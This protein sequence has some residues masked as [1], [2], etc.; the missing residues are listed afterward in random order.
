MSTQKPSGYWTLENTIAEVKAV[1]TEHGPKA[2][3]SNWLK[4][5]GHSGLNAAICGHGGIHRVR[6]L[7]GLAPSGVKPVGYWTLEN[8]VA[9]VKVIADEHGPEAVTADWLTHN[10]HSGLGHAIRRRG[11]LSL[12]RELADLAGPERKPLGYWTLENTVA[13]VKTVAAEHGPEAVTADWLIR[14][15]HSSLNTAIG[16]HGGLHHIRELAGL[17]GPERK[18]SG[19]WTLENTVAEVKAI[20]AKH[21][22]EA[23]T[24][25]WLNRNGYGGLG[26]AMRQ[27]GGFPRIRELAG[28]PDRLTIYDQL[29]SDL[30]AL[31]ESLGDHLHE[32]PQKAWLRIIKQATAKI[33][34]QSKLHP[35]KVKLLTGEIGPGDIL[36]PPQPERPDDDSAPAEPPAISKLQAELDRLRDADADDDDDVQDVQGDVQDVVD[37]VQDDD[38]ERRAQLIR[39]T[40]QRVLDQMSVIA[41]TTSDE[42]AL[43]SIRHDA[44]ERLWQRLF[45][46][47]DQAAEVAAIRAAVPADRWASLLRDSF[48]ADWRLIEEIGEI[49]GFKAD[50]GFSLN[51]MQRR[52]AALLLRDRARLNIS[53]MGGGKTLA[54]IAAAH[55]CGCQ[56]VLVLAPNSALSAWQSELS[57][58][59]PDTAVASK[60][61][62]PHWMPTDQPRW[63]LNNHEMLGDYSA[64]ELAVFIE[65]HEPDAVIIDE[66][67]LCKMRDERSESQRHRNLSTLCDQLRG[68]AVLLGL[69]GTPVV[70]ELGEAIGLLQLIR[71]DLAAGLKPGHTIDNCMAVHEALQPISSR[72]IP[73][74]PCTV[75]E[76]HIE[77]RADHL[78]DDAVEAC[79]QHP[80]SID[81]VLAQAKLGQLVT[82]C[83]RPGKTVVFTSSVKGVVDAARDALN[84]AGIRCVVHTGQEKDDAGV[85]SVDLFLR[86]PA[87]RVL[88]ASTGTLATGFDGLQTVCARLCYLTLPWTPAEYDQSKHRVIRQGSTATEIELFTISAVLFD[89]EGEEDWSYDTQKLGVLTGKRTV[90][91]AVT[92]G[93]IPDQSAL[94][95]SL[96]EARKAHKKMLKRVKETS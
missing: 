91:A 80:A 14:N 81:A 72:Y 11:G 70:N 24:S 1:A 83:Q 65:A 49:P 29:S 54:A 36:P 87:V 30:A 13:E 17:A 63:L 8:I 64:Q 46:S 77:V 20:A 26:S 94:K 41:S 66:L 7:A 19:Y 31:I 82:I 68:S 85:P 39:L 52:E 16:K 58:H 43:E 96:T 23:V 78:Y 86:D 56:R 73:P 25:R 55:L 69:T 38:D 51:L 92:D 34:S 59:F 71:P 67:H 84:A 27:H 40:P 33:G 12:V 35:I 2:V 18:P 42:A 22:H 74:L 62:H 28:L 53:G 32:L 60:T 90:M 88:I 5:N 15:G 3:T 50:A 93:V 89:P 76:Q 61:W 4:R 37:G 48:L 9:E 6:E 79:G 21:G 95:F 45:L 57:Q 44:V 75:T 10:G 47:D